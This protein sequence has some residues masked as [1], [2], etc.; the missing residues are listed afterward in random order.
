MDKVFFRGTWHKFAKRPPSLPQPVA[1]CCIN[2]WNRIEAVQYEYARGRLGEYKQPQMR[3]DIAR[4][5]YLFITNDGAAPTLVSFKDETALASESQ[6]QS[7]W[8][9]FKHYLQI[10]RGMIRID[11]IDPNREAWDYSR[12]GDP[13]EMDRDAWHALGIRLN[14]AYAKNRRHPVSGTEWHKALALI[15]RTINP[16]FTTSRSRTLDPRIRARV[17]QDIKEQ[18][19]VRQAEKRGISAPARRIGDRTPV[20]N[21]RGNALGS[22]AYHAIDAG[23]YDRNDRGGKFSRKTRVLLRAEKHQILEDLDATLKAHDALLAADEEAQFFRDAYLTRAQDNVARRAQG[24]APRDSQ[25][26]SSHG[27]ITEGDDPRPNGRGNAGAG[28]ASG[29]RSKPNGNASQALSAGM[30]N[31]IA[32]AQATADAAVAITRDGVNNA[33]GRLLPPLS[34]ELEEMS[35]R[36][37]ALQRRN[38]I[39][40]GL[41]KAIDYSL[42]KYGENLKKLEGTRLWFATYGT[43][44]NGRPTFDGDA[45]GD[46]KVAIHADG[47]KFTLAVPPL[48]P[49]AGY[50]AFLLRRARC[51]LVRIICRLYAMLMGRIGRHSDQI[52]IPTAADQVTLHSLIIS[53]ITT[54]DNLDEKRRV[55]SN[56]VRPRVNDVTAQLT[57]YSRTFDP[58][59]L[60]HF[61]HLDVSSNFSLAT[62]CS[63]LD[64]TSGD[65]AGFVE[66]TIQNA[67]RDVYVNR[68]VAC[69][70]MGLENL[71]IAHY[72]FRDGERKRLGLSNPRSPEQWQRFGD[73]LSQMRTSTS[74]LLTETLL[75][76][77][78]VLGG[79]LPTLA[80]LWAEFTPWP[81]A[82]LMVIPCTALLYHRSATQLGL[83]PAQSIDSA[84]TCALAYTALSYLSSALVSWTIS[85][86][87]SKRTF[88]V[89]AIGSRVARILLAAVRL[90]L[91]RQ[92]AWARG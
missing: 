25:I 86:L 12:W 38:G 14:K 30:A 15:N 50:I 31:A 35:T 26:G 85:Y 36:A 18:Q 90:L 46:Y 45:V 56:G 43:D 8:G 66:N 39:V 9:R 1:A 52:L 4:A 29:P 32:D 72:M 5:G 79:L 62:Y 21:T 92:L 57:V 68:D 59:G 71:L 37:L 28:S 13:P 61:R 73:T 51:M 58:D 24:T 10:L 11:R 20:S 7:D 69:M 49:L 81:R 48:F 42:G 77:C 80:P 88:P 33:T 64:R 47:V 82:A 3:E 17:K 63:S 22:H 75:S 89:S 34:D 78:V 74:G 40:A 84:V 55:T 87:W 67:A 65:I 41:A 27:E 76:S 60:D 54:H 2:L 6:R 70:D 19:R 91:R 83:L 53:D 44:P 23:G 16:G